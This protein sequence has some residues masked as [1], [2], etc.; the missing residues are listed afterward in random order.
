M[1]EIIER[2]STPYLWFCGSVAEA[3][4]ACLPPKA[5]TKAIRNDDFPCGVVAIDGCAPQHEVLGPCGA[6]PGGKQGSKLVCD[7]APKG[8]P[9]PHPRQHPHATPQRKSLPAHHHLLPRL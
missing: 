9:I 7:S 4:A 1:E 2:S 6:R 8:K 5:P 3:T